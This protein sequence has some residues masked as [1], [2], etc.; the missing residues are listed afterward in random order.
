MPCGAGERWAFQLATGRSGL[1]YVAIVA[2]SPRTTVF[3]VVM[4][5]RIGGGG[6]ACGLP[7]AAEPA[8]KP[9]GVMVT[10]QVLVLA[11][12]VR[13]LAGLFFGCATVTPSRVRDG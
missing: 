3:V 10:H 4:M 2:S 9:G 13:V 1:G 6:C 8:L 5:C 11:F 7:S 12:Q